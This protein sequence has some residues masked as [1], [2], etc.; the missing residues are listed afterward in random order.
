MVENILGYAKEHHNDFLEALK[1]ITRI[2][3]ISAFAENVDDVRDCAKAVVKQMAE[4]GLENAQLLEMEGA[5][6]CAYGEW[7]HGGEDKP[8]VLLYAHYDVQP[9]GDPKR[10]LSDP[11]EPVEREG[12]LYARGIVDDKA[13]VT[14]HLAALESY[15]KSEGKLPLNVKMIVEGEEEIGSSHLENYLERHKEM[16]QADVIVLS[17]THNLDTGIPSITYALRGIL[18]LDVELHALRQSLHSG[19][20]GGPIPNPIEELSKLLA[21]LT[22]EDG[23]IAIPGIYEDV[24]EMTSSEREKLDAISF[25]EKKFREQAGVLEG[26]DLLT[27][28]GKSPYE[29]MW[30][31]PSLTVTAFESNEVASAPNQIIQSAKARITIRMVPDMDAKK[32]ME[33]LKKYLAEYTPHGLK[34]E[35][36][37][38]D[39]GNW[40]KTVP[41]GEAFDMASRALEKGYD[42]PVAFI[43]CGGSIPFV[44]PFSKALGGVPALLLGLEDPTCNAH[45]ENESLH[46]G[47]FEKAIKANIHLY[48]E[49]SQLKK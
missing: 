24:H 38:E 45:S 43:G 31:Q 16:L 18:M 1:T 17:D 19:S 8:T 42:H 49:L 37:G 36:Q 10:W 35:F 12:R 26:V 21:G 48:Q 14:T 2:P 28:G 5:A 30:L 9:L 20:W 39:V 44:E 22:D 13:G 40:W 7:L 34:L 11:F 6:P 4:A 15:M 33:Q 46:L 29:L 23:K 41:E 25:S 27:Q 32:T 47:D 3:S